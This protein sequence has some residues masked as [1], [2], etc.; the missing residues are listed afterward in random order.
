M[1][2]RSSVT[3]ED[4]RNFWNENPLCAAA[5]PH[6][7]GTPDYFSFYDKLREANESLEFSY[8]LHEYG[9]FSGKKVLDVGCGNGYV[10]SKYA[11]EG[12]ETFGVDIT[13]TAI[14]LCRKRFDQE[15]LKGD[16]RVANAED[17]PFE[18]ETFDCVCAMGVLHHTPRTADAVSEIHR[19]LKKSGKLIVMFY[20]RNSAYH[21]VYM[22]LRYLFT[23]RSVKDQVN[24]V[25]GKG[26][27]KGDVYSRR[28]LRD[29]LSAFP[30][31]EMFAGLLTGAMILPR[32]GGFLFPDTLLKTLERRFGWFLYAK[33]VKR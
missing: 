32:V 28:Q 3:I 18:A 13:E 14:D 6:P 31:V 9:R 29:L 17:L 24:E 8:F 19:V 21:R 16:F 1:V 12:A 15:R 27:P 10:L 4:V 11:R 25:D 30:Q 23:G 5:I 2:E 7:I 22:P 26:N 20:H 33:A